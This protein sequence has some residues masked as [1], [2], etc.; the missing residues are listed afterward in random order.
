[1]SISVISFLASFETYLKSF[2]F[3]RLPFGLVGATMTYSKAIDGAIKEVPPGTAKQ[4]VDDAIVAL[5]HSKR[6]CTN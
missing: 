6:C 2:I 4:Y 3:K 1:M 5:T